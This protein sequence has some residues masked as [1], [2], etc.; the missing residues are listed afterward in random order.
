MSNT[1]FKVIIDITWKWY[2]LLHQFTR[3]LGLCKY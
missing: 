2:K 1:V 3:L